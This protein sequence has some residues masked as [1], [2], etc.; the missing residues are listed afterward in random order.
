ME[1][2]DLKFLQTLVKSHGMTHRDVAKVAGYSSHSYVGRLM[3]GQVKRVEPTPAARIARRFE[4]DVDD[5]FVRTA[6]RNAGR[7][8]QSRRRAAA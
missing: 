8:N 5:L 6:A 2:R 1:V 7:T 4:V 3:R